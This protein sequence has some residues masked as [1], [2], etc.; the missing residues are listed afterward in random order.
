MGRRGF[1]CEGDDVLAADDDESESAFD[2]FVLSGFVCLG[3]AILFGV[4]QDDVHVLVEGQEGADH[5][6]GVLECDSHSEVDPLQELAPLRC[7]F[8][9]E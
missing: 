3:D 4:G 8:I 5:H 1:C 2:L 9:I 7:H 6:A